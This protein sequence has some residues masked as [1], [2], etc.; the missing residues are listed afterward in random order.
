[1]KLVNFLVFV[2]NLVQITGRLG[3]VHFLFIDDQEVL[4]VFLLVVVL[5]ARND[6][7]PLGVDVNLN[8]MLCR[9]A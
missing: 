3:K 5:A 8:G 4:V 1:M 9:L 6:D 7:D 2:D